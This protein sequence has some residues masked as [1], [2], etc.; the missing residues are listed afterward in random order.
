MAAGEMNIQFGTY[1]LRTFNDQNGGIIIDSLHHYNMHQYDFQAIL[2]NSH[3]F[4]GKVV[5]EV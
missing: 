5:L 4:R 2:G 1:L 3:L